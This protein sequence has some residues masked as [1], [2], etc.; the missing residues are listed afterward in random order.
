[1]ILK[2][3]HGC[4]LPV[5]AATIHDSY[6]NTTTSGLPAGVSNQVHELV[7]PWNRPAPVPVPAP[8]PAGPSQKRK[9]DTG[10]DDGTGTWKQPAKRRSQRIMGLHQLNDSHKSGSGGPKPGKSQSEAVREWLEHIED[11]GSP[12][13][14]IPVS[15]PKSASSGERPRGEQCPNAPSVPWERWAYGPQET[16]AGMCQ[17]ANIGTRQ[18]T[19]TPETE[20]TISGPWQRR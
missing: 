15:P 8:T 7:Q 12:H 17:R 13:G 3:L 14:A 20:G 16:A 2:T 4:F 5:L 19:S 10:D 1:M 9:P 6:G 11:V 18:I